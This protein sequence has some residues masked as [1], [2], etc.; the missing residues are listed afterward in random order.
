M[1]DLLGMEVE[2]S[3]PEVDIELTKFF[4]DNFTTETQDACNSALRLLFDEGLQSPEAAIMSIIAQSEADQG[5]LCA[6]VLDMLQSEIISL[7]RRLGVQIDIR[8]YSPRLSEL[9][10][11]YKALLLVYEA[12]DNLELADQIS[13]LAALAHDSDEFLRE[14]IVFFAGNSMFSISEH[15]YTRTFEVVMN[16]P[17]QEDP[18]LTSEHA[19]FLKTLLAYYTGQGYTC[20]VFAYIKEHKFALPMQ[21]RLYQKFLPTEFTAVEPKNSPLQTAL[22]L[23]S[24]ASLSSDGY[25]NPFKSIIE[26][27]LLKDS[28]YKVKAALEQQISRFNAFRMEHDKA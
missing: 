19:K 8:S 28:D 16:T 6:A 4:R 15:V 21:H 1:S 13:H 3:P 5:S 14:A 12:Y 26:L 22:H 25:S 10:K 27:K 24:I 9:V 23:I 7:I 2:T 17:E 18:L 11:V 20:P